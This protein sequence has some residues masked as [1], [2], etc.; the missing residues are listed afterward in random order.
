MA[1]LMYRRRKKI[2]L[3]IVISP[4]TRYVLYDVIHYLILQH[5]LNFVLVHSHHEV[6]LL[7]SEGNRHD[8]RLGRVG[9]EEIH[10]HFVCLGNAN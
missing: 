6:Q 7:R 1:I 9:N 2:A 10:S 8:N 5:V 4:S 3:G